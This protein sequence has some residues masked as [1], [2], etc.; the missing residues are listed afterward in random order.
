MSG[1]IKFYERNIIDLTNTNVTISVTDSVATNTGSTFADYM[2][3]RKNTSAWI[4]TGSSDAGTTTLIVD[5]TESRSLEKIIII[6]HNFKAYTVKYW[7]GAAYVDFSTAIAETAYADTD[8]FH[9]F[10]AISTIKIQ[11]IITETQVADEDKYIK[12]LI[13]I[14]ERAQFDAYPDIK[15]PTHDNGKRVTKMLSGKKNIVSAVGA[16]NC[17]LAVSTLSNAADLALIEQLFERKVGFLVLLSGEL[18]SQFKNVLAGYRNEDIYLM[19]CSNNYEPEFYKYCYQ[20]GTKVK[21]KLTEVI[22]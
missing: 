1:Q 6:G 12:Q 5:M 15:N 17:E 2:R 16:F 9:D 22:A 8:S 11:I 13:L 3:N 14:E 21:M 10:T 4:T 7:N 18:E 19:K 20:L